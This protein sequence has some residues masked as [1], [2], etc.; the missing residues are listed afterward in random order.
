[1]NTNVKLDFNKILNE[2]MAEMQALEQPA[3]G[4]NYNA[5]SQ[6]NVSAPGYIIK[7]N[8]ILPT[9]ENEENKQNIEETLYYNIKN[10]VL[11]SKTNKFLKLRQI[12]KLID[13]Y[14]NIN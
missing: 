14:N 1:M 6:L 7:G 10:I 13:D 8:N 11:N 3:L 12:L 4:G 2:T 9:E 5:P